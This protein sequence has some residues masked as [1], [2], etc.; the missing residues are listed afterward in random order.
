M[1]LDATLLNT[2]HCKVQIK[3]KVDNLGM[4]W[5]PPLHFGIVGI[6]RGAFGSSSTKVANFTYLL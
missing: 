5:R 1:I 2:Q 3:G 6:E 4:E